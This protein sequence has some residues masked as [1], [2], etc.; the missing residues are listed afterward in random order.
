MSLRADLQIMRGLHER[1]SPEALRAWKRLPYVLAPVDGFL[2]YLARDVGADAADDDGPRGLSDLVPSIEHVPWDAA[3]IDLNGPAGGIMTRPRTEYSNPDLPAHVVARI[4]T[5]AGAEA[6]ATTSPWLA[7]IAPVMRQILS[8]VETPTYRPLLAA[9]EDYC[10]GSIRCQQAIG[11]GWRPTV[12]LVDLRDPW[13]ERKAIVANIS[14][15]EMRRINEAGASEASFKTVP[16]MVLQFLAYLSLCDQHL[17]ERRAAGKEAGSERSRRT[18]RLKPWLDERLPQVILID[19]DRV[20]DFRTAGGGTGGAHASPCPHQRRGHWKTLS[21][22]RFKAARGRRL[23][24]KPLWVG[25][26]VWERDGQVYRVLFP[27]GFSSSRPRAS[28]SG[29]S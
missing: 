3:V 13:V 20:G 19:P 26:R 12:C 22:E 15:D 18:A 28:A 1:V 8:A 21:A 5:L 9:I 24:I 2:D 16:Y 25:D 4:L 10:S 29:A 14:D 27:E 7:D 17:V 23:W 6:H 11:H